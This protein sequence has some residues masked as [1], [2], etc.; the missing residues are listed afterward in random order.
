MAEAD[1]EEHEQAGPAWSEEL[2]NWMLSEK[3]GLLVKAQR[4]QRR[5][6]ELGAEVERLRARGAGA[7]REVQRLLVSQC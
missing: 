2:L 4:A 1:F 5:Q 6:Q 3:A 7:E